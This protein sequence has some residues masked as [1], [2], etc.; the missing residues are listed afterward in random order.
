[1]FNA[2]PFPISTAGT[3]RLGHLLGTNDPRSA[4]RASQVIFI[5]TIFGV[6]ITSGVTFLSHHVIG[7]MFTSD[8]EV[9][10]EVSHLI[11]I[12]SIVQI[13]DGIQCCGSGLFRG[14]GKHHTVALL[15][16]FSFWVFGL[17]L[18]ASLAFHTEL[19]LAGIW[20]GNASGVICTS[21]LMVIMMSRVD[22]AKEAQNARLRAYT[23]TTH[24]SLRGMIVP[25]TEAK[26][27]ISNQDEEQLFDDDGEEGFDS[28]L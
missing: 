28:S 1:M 9:I 19:G 15:N 8:E 7:H 25:L 12:V 3:I 5:L 6:F 4:V 10:L 22:W 21:V 11:L 18:G 23:E 20:W 13:F 16:F 26:K 2:L 17:G 14:M 24:N 27:L